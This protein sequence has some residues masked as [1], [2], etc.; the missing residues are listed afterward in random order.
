MKIQVAKFFQSLFLPRSI[1][2]L[3]WTQNN[4]LLVWLGSDNRLG[5]KSYDEL[6]IILFTK[7]IYH[8]IQCPLGVLRGPCLVKVS[9]GAAENFLQNFLIEFSHQKNSDLKIIF[10]LRYKKTS[11]LTS[12]L[13]SPSSIQKLS[14]WDQDEIDAFS[15]RRDIRLIGKHN[16]AMLGDNL[17]LFPDKITTGEKKW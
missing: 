4:K 16:N 11:T 13:C 5:H 9:L 8:K 15:K 7:D 6:Q 2:P 17:L 12:Q 1:T 10:K 3:A 14:V